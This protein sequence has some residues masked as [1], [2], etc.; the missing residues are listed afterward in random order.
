MC[1]TWHTIGERDLRGTVDEEFGFRPDKVEKRARLYALSKIAQESI[2]RYF[3]EMSEK[4]FGIIRL[5]TA[6]GYW[7]A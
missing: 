1:G 4:V 2:V 3:D 7:N 6:L 5:G